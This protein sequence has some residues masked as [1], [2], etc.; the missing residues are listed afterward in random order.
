M[1]SH[2]RASYLADVTLISSLLPTSDFKVMPLAITPCLLAPVHIC[3]CVIC[4]HVFTQLYS[5]CRVLL[6]KW[7]LPNYILR[8]LFH[9][10]ETQP[11]SSSD[12][13]NANRL[14]VDSLLF[15]LAVSVQLPFFLYRQGEDLQVLFLGPSLIT[16]RYDGFL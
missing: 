7:E 9:L 6:A 5:V 1:L 14:L 13:G 12:S 3:T 10:W 11:L 15:L 4:I 8:F 2:S 16:E